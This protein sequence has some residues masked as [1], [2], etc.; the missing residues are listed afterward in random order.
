[1]KR[2]LLAL[3]LLL[4][5]ITSLFAWNSGAK[6]G[7]N[8]F[9]TLGWMTAQP[10]YATVH[11]EGNR[12]PRYTV[13]QKITSRYCPDCG[14]I[15]NV[16]D[17]QGF[18]W[19]I[20]LYNTKNVYF[21]ITA[22][23]PELAWKDPT[24]FS[25]FKADGVTLSTGNIMAPRCANYGYP[26]WQGPYMVGRLTVA[27]GGGCDQPRTTSNWPNQSQ[28]WGP[29]KMNF[30]GDI[31]NGSNTMIVAYYWSTVNGAW[32]VQERQYFVEGFGLV[33]WE[34]WKR[35]S[36]GSFKMVDQTT[37]DRLVEGNL[38]NYQFPCNP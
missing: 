17:A 38:P 5:S 18:P 27:P 7:P 26:G 28:V 15:Y 22:A 13:I 25:V 4:S 2:I 24:E 1:M 31:P 11:G 29:Y 35:Q 8:Q 36:D 19:D 33:R 16:N 12:H 10:G 34:A 23:V 6:C 21:W 37:F 14:V 32:G 9:D 20:N 3:G 30:G